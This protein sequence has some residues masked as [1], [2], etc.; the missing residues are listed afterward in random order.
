MFKSLKTVLSNKRYFLVWLVLS[1]VFLFIY[2]VLPINLTPGNTL[3][4]FLR[5][6]PLWQLFVLSSLA[7]IIALMITMQLYVRGVL[8]V[9]KGT[10]KT[11]AVGIFTSLSSAVSGLFSSVTC[12]SCV[13]GLFAFLGVGSSF[14]FLLLQYQWEISAISF[15]LAFT[16]IYYSTKRIAGKACEFC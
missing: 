4:F 9:K 2:I 3:D 14:T 8:N 7:M 15:I 12:S 11:V 1:L 10:T 6:T 16:S 13:A 5:I